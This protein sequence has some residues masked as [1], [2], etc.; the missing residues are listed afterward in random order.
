VVKF[1]YLDN[2]KR[3]LMQR[4]KKDA[5]SLR[6]IKLEPRQAGSFLEGLR[7][8]GRVPAGPRDKRPVKPIGEE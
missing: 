1:W 7:R 3:G 4:L 2:M 8:L 5:Q 6:V